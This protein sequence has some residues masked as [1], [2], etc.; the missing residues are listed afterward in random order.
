MGGREGLNL[1]NNGSQ[2]FALPLSYGHSQRWK[3]RTSARRVQVANAT[4]TPIPVDLVRG[5]QGSNLRLKLWRQL[6]FH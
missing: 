4:T 6:V 1:H 5:W 3:N 2:P